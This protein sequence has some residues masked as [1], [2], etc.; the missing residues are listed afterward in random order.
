MMILKTI[1]EIVSII[2]IGSVILWFFL[3]IYIMIQIGREDYK[4]DN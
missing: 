1:T 2:L 3:M 4:N